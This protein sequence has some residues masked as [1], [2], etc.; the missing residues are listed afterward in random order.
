[1]DDV[2]T[3]LVAGLGVA[4]LAA[5]IFL[6][7]VAIRAVAARAG[8]LARP[9]RRSRGIEHEGSQEWLYRERPST[10]QSRSAT[11]K[12]EAR[13]SGKGAAELTAEEIRETARQEA[14]AVLRAAELR[15]TEVFSD[16]ERESRLLRQQLASERRQLSSLLHSVLDEVKRGSDEQTAEVR[17][18]AR[19]RE[20][21]D[22]S[23]ASE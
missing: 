14:E 9:G 21:R 16:A 20:L 19:V 12:S 18:L 6:M 5:A 15:A 7:L 4:V 3:P 11:D 13:N 1:M 2:L 10:T 23:E 8:R 17:D 22:V